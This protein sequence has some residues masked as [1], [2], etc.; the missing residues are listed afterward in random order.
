MNYS[1]AAVRVKHSKYVIG[2]SILDIGMLRLY[3][4]RVAKPALRGGGCRAGLYPAGQIGS[5]EVQGAYIIRLLIPTPAD[6]VYSN[7]HPVPVR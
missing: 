5:F 2:Y 3:Q 7:F 4:R 1:V 6:F